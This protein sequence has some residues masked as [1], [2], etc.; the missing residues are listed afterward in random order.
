MNFVKFFF[1][2]HLPDQNVSRYTDINPFDALWEL[3][4]IS[5]LNK[6]IGSNNII[7]A[8]G[9][10][11]GKCVEEGSLLLTP[12]GPKKIENIITGDT[13][14]SG[15]SWQKVLGTIDEGVKE[16]FRLTTRHSTR[17]S[18]NTVTGSAN[19]RVQ[20]DIGGGNIDWV[21]V[22]D[23]KPDQ[24]VYRSIPKVCIDISSQDYKEGWMV[25]VI[26]GD[27]AVS[28]HSV[29]I[30]VCGGDFKMLREY[31]DLAFKRFGLKHEVKRNSARSVNLSSTNSDLINWF[32]TFVKGDLSYHKELITLEH[33]NEFL[34]GFIS[35]L[36]DTDGSKDG[37]TLSNKTLIDQIHKILFVL[38][39]HSTINPRRRKPRASKL[40]GGQLAE[41]QMC[42]WKTPLNQA[43]MPRF[44]KKNDFLTYAAKMNE[45]FR[46]PNSVVAAFGLYIKNKYSI[47]GGYWT[48]DGVKSRSN[49]KYHKDLWSSKP[50]GHTCGYKI[51]SFIDLANTLKEKEWAYKLKFIKD[52]VFEKVVS[53]DRTTAHLY[54]L[55][56]ANDHSYWANGYV[57]HN[58]L[59]VSIAQLL[60]VIHG[61]RDVVHVGAILS[62]AERCYQYVQGFLLSDKIRPIVSPANV[63]EQFRMLKKDTMHKSVI[64]TGGRDNTIEILPCTLKSVN[65]P[66]VSF[67]T[68]DEI[69]TLQT[70]ENMRAYKDIS[71]MLDSRDGKKAIRVDISTR[72]S[73]HGLMNQLMENAE[74]SGKILRRWTVFEF[75]RRC[76]DSRSGTMKQNY[77][78]DQMKFDIK[79]PEDHAKLP[80]SQKKEYLEY[81]MLSG[82]YRCPLAPVCLGDARKQMSKSPMLKTIDEVA[83]KV[84]AEGPDWCL[85][86]LMNLKPS[87]EGIVFKEF[88]ERNHIL[89]WNQMWTKLTSTDFPGVCDHD[90]FVKKCL[91]MGLQAYAGIDW[92]WSNPSTLVVFFV[93]RK[94]NIYV[95][96]CDG[97]TY[98]SNPAWIHHVKTKWHSKY[99]ISLYFPDSANPGDIKEM[100]LAGLTASDKAGKSKIETGIQIIKKWL[101]SPGTASPKL[102][103]ADETC[104][105]LIKEFQT[106][107]YKTSA[108]GQIGDDFDKGNDHWLDALRY[109]IEGIF[110]GNQ[111]V[112]SSESMESMDTTNIV[113]AKGE[114]F[115]P[116]TPEEWMRVNGV[117]AHLPTS[118]SKLGKVGRLSEL[119]TAEDEDESSGGF[120]W[121]F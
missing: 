119:D 29:N 11:S 62:Q 120:S 9:R 69:D 118:E 24:I 8:A 101:R 91:S 76:P 121:S 115:K 14:F 113:N 66:H 42:E 57:N 40:L 71:G 1:G 86:Q 17:T 72:K 64:N 58:T 117:S 25:G 94:E 61:K 78:I 97:Q 20:A 46:Y 99:K 56:V 79:L 53:V 110:G 18:T 65:G 102:F 90:I 50:E 114:Y 105:P 111:A 28:R 84:L 34:A 74:K 81:D 15:W 22:P 63:P 10:G 7:Y 33:S 83:A 13:V 107:H 75:T 32:K 2:L 49:V 96:R 67:V 80:D 48:V 103:L 92:G 100:N 106:F 44:S 41:Y 37:I 98:A 36:M 116:P 38:G 77:F 85:S 12:T 16:S 95:V 47:G 68:V 45:Q 30:T 52:G 3:Y 112:L 88:D 39:T 70:G 108:D 73:R 6:D 4:Q 23:L 54:D 31:A 104:Q 59:V 5:V 26:T 109:V 27:G 51:D 55:E 60:A 87:V 93:D 43:C 89:N 35:G 21:Y 82:C 19:H